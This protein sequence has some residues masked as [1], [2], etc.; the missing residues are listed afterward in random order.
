MRQS[1]MACAWPAAVSL[2]RRAPPGRLPRELLASAEHWPVAP[3]RQSPLSG[4]EMANCLELGAYI[5]QARGKF[6]LPWGLPWPTLLAVALP[7]L[8]SPAPPLRMNSAD[9]HASREPPSADSVRAG[10]LRGCLSGCFWGCLCG[11]LWMF[12][13]QGFLRFFDFLGLSGIAVPI[14][15]AGA[16]AGTIGGAQGARAGAARG[17]RAPVAGAMV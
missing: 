4:W 16:T 13:F 1:A 14:L 9:A 10:C 17:S 2:S 12:L 7:A 6:C 5:S 3:P 11:A 8:G 15:A